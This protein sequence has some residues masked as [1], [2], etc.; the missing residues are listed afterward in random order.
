MRHCLKD[1]YWAVN[2]ITLPDI[3]CRSV[4]V[5]FAFN[6]ACVSSSLGYEIIATMTAS[7]SH[8]IHMVSQM[9]K[10]RHQPFVS[11]SIVLSNQQKAKLPKKT[12][13][14]RNLNTTQLT[15]WWIKQNKKGAQIRLE[16][17]YLDYPWTLSCKFI[18]NREQIKLFHEMWAVSSCT[19]V[20]TGPKKEKKKAI[21]YHGSFLRTE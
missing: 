16:Y 8:T 21:A 2:C 5:I 3:L 6:S 17:K 19:V 12:G 1:G 18:T 7:S 20:C 9:M 13:S 14:L 10:M 11:A 4:S 15:Q